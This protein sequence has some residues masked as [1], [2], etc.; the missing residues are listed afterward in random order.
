M[1]DIKIQNEFDNLKSVIVGIA[2]N[3][4]GISMS[5]DCYNPKSKQHVQQYHY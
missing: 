3:F 2:H 1:F 4:D 5:N